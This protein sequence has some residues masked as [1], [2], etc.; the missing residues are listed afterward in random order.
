M[1]NSKEEGFQELYDLYQKQMISKETACDELWNVLN[2]NN[3]VTNRPSFY[4]ILYSIKYLLLI[5]SSNEAIIKQKEN[6]YYTL[7]LWFLSIS[8]SLNFELLCRLFIY[9]LPEDQVLIIKRLFHMAEENQFELTIEKLDC[10]LRIDADLYELIKKE[11][12]Q[13]PIDL[14][15][16]III[17]SLVN[18]SKNNQFLTDKDVLNIVIKNGLYNKREEFKIG[19]YFDECK[20]RFIFNKKKKIAKGFIKNNNDSYFNVY[21]FPMVEERVYTNGIGYNY[22]RIPNR[23]FDVIK[24]AVKGLKGR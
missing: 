7:I 14:S 18:L 20:G 3:E 11:Q 16:E 9:F 22:Q 10:L 17:K 8:N 21:I 5:N 1:L 19:N 4:T 13:V 15:S 24:N 23:Y 12:P 6:D 2:Q